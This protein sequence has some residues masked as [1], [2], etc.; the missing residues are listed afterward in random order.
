MGT[1]RKVSNFEY[2]SV[3]CAE[4]SFAPSLVGEAYAAGE[5]EAALRGMVS[6]SSLPP[7]EYEGSPAI[8]TCQK[9]GRRTCFSG[10]CTPCLERQEVDRE[11]TEAAR[12]GY[13]VD[14]QGVWRRR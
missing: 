3:P 12:Q 2:I 1:A 7:E 11:R 14:S 5:R 4:N 9:C 6:Q 13:R 8:Y 10:L